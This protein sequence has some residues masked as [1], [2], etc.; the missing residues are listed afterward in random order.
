LRR[1][2]LV[3]RYDVIIGRIVYLL[4]TS[5]V[6]ASLLPVPTAT[7]FVRVVSLLCLFVTRSG[8]HQVMCRVYLC[9]MIFP[10][11][12]VILTLIAV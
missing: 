4:L 6:G 1:A 12:S 8:L 10:W 9:T 7:L 3:V 5:L 2:V 11:S